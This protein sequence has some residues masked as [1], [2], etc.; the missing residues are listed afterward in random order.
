MGYKG[1][2]HTSGPSVSEEEGINVT[3]CNG[4]PKFNNNSLGNYI[5]SDKS[6]SDMQHWVVSV[7]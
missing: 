3:I 1:K 4:S 7:V 6:W 5:W 2:Y